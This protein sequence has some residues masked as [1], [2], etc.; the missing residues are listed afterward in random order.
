MMKDK[1]SDIKKKKLIWERIKFCRFFLVSP[2]VKVV[3]R[4]LQWLYRHS[5]R[6][7]CVSNTRFYYY[8]DMIHI[9][10]IIIMIHHQRTRSESRQ[11]VKS[12]NIH[13]TTE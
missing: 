9:T 1:S 2:A 8:Y 4:N 7:I 6:H 13:H 12:N 10:I 3:I 5:S 11:E